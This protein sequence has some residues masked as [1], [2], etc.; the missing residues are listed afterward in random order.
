M[1]FWVIFA[2]FSIF[3]LGFIGR[4]E[5][6][7]T[8]RKIIQRL[9]GKYSKQK[10]SD[11][12]YRETL[13]FGELESPETHIVIFPGN[14]GHCTFYDEFCLQLVA[15]AKGKLRVTSVSL[16]NFVLEPPRTPAGLNDQ[17]IHY[18]RFVKETIERSQRTKGKETHQKPTKLVFISHSVGA[19]I[20]LRVLDMLEN[21]EKQL[22]AHSFLMFPTFMH[23][24]LTVKG[25]RLFWLMT[26]VVRNI[27]ASIVG[28][29]FFVPGAL[30]RAAIN[31]VLGKS[32][33]QCVKDTAFLL[34]SYRVIRNILYLGYEELMQIKNPPTKILEDWSERLTIYYS[35]K[36]EW[37]REKDFEGL[38][39]SLDK[40]TVLK[41]QFGYAHEF[42]TDD[43]SKM[44]GV[45]T[46][47]LIP[48]WTR[49]IRND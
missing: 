23:M 39:S 4:F 44:V 40:L 5:M 20:V 11:G 37:T 15:E 16:S 49:A 13:D 32:K 35:E 36:D 31:L 28:L 24:R 46:T 3:V 12:F 42:V 26:P 29:L 47:Q 9:H 30:K 22:V 2:F 6:K 14:P 48:K 21:Q 33:P 25:R 43:V 27:A 1:L 10:I 17:I 45:L 34:L 41:D 18:H 38:R 8:K 19:Y 7:S